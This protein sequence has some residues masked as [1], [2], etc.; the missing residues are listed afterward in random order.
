[1]EKGE[2]KR[3]T[4]LKSEYLV[5]RPWLTARRDMVQLPNG[6]IN[7]EYYV[8]E[9]P[10][11]VN[12]IAITADG[13]FVFVRQYRYP[14]ASE[15]LEIPAGIMEAGETPVQSAARELREETGYR[16]EQWTHLS[17][18]W[19]TPGFSNEKIYLFFA[20][21]LVW[22]PLSPDEDEDISL[23]HLTEDEARALFLRSEAQDAKTLAAL[24]WYFAS[25]A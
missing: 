19:T 22:D 24:G 4:T 14:I 5:K 15:L 11:W 20:E 17:S 7:D 1:M 10:D 16:A 8:L 9:Y 25:K 21:K 2:S 3:W 12:V 13:Q 18:I 23:T 6:V